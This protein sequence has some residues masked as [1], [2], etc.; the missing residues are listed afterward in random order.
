MAQ[1]GIAR[2]RALQQQARRVAQR[3]VIAMW[4]N[5]VMARPGIAPQTHL[6]RRGRCVARQPGIVTYSALGRI[7]RFGLVD[8]NATGRTVATVR[9]GATVS[10]RVA[11]SWVSTGSDCPG[12]L[13]QFYARMNGVFSVCFGNTTGNTTFDRM[14][15][16]TAPSTPGVYVINPAE[17]WD[18]NCV[19]DTGA[20]TG[21]DTSS[22]ATLVVE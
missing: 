12:C 8:L 7:A 2:Q 19:T 14:T 5:R 9:A 13:T 17:T 22:L 1:A 6:R 10:L 11:G 3:S 18:F 21:F 20:R 16:F 4:P 15:M